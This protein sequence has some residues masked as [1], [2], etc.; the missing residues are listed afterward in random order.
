MLE[1]LI[2][3]SLG[4]RIFILAGALLIVIAGFWSLGNLN[5]D[6]FPD[7]T[8]VQVQINTD[9]P[10]LVATE[11]ERLVT[12]PIEALMGGMPGL[13]HVRSIS[14]FGVSQ[15]VVTFDDGTDVYLVRQIINE[16]LSTLP[17]P[18]G[19]PRPEL[20]PVA[21]GLGEVFHYMLVPESETGHDLMDLRR[22][23]DWEIK[24]A[25]RIIPGAAEINTWGGLAK[26]YQIRVDPVKLFEHD[27]TPQQLMQAVRTNNLNV[28]GGY[29]VRGGD[30][31]V[32][33]GIGRT[34]DIPQIEDIM[35]AAKDGVPIFLS[36]VAEVV[37]GHEIRKGLVTAEGRGEVVLGLGFMRIGENSYGVTHRFRTAL[38][39]LLPL[40]PERLKVVLLYDRTKLV[41]QVISTVRN[42]LCEG[43]FLVVAILFLFLGNLRA[44]LIC[45][46]SIPVS[47]L[48]AFCGMYQAEVAG[49]LLSLG[50][51]DFGIVVDSS[52]VVLERIVSRLAR[53]GAAHG[54]GRIKIIRDAAIEVRKPAVFGQLII[55]IVYI[56][57]LSLQGVEGKMFRP[58]AITVVFVLMGSLLLSLT[59]T[60][61]AASFILPRVIDEEEV[62]LVRLARR[63]YAPLLRAG[64]R[65]PGAILGM[66]AAA[67]F[68]AAM[69]AMGL[70]AEF[71]PQLAEGAI[72]VDVRRVPGTSLEQSAE[73]NTQMERALLA[74][75]PD[76]IERV[77]S[78]CGKPEVNTDTGTAESTDL[79]ISLRPREEWKRARAQ[80]ELIGLIARE[81]DQFK[82]QDI[83]FSKPIEMRINE[84]LTGIR[85]D[86]A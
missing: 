14:Q 49:T 2:T 40:L 55:M 71:V 82:G 33:Q 47:M 32:V 76:E 66:A 70:G 4:N 68:A 54:P 17:M 56:P 24:P 5:F 37:I 72:V 48:F 29:I 22:I 39:E 9:A 53:D 46:A 60:P 42:N 26:Q 15:V 10:A 79:F 34:R 8:P 52:V 59:L 6:A 86:V 11:V 83:R 18:P 81:L 35:I 65:L 27:L 7:T 12:F 20:G 36:D 64:L 75:F 80:S 25:L 63:L 62:F 41:D 30:M 21:T 45:A 44:G 67:L 69:V 85:A 77:W 23:Q 74:A 50:A 1:K 19:I 31:L 13:K 73:S 61:V 51:I 58:M 78:R 57:I 38:E 16:R 3:W 28:G 43:G 84:M